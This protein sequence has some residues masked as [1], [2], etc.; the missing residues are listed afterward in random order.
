[1]TRAPLYGEHTDAVLATLA[2][3]TAD[4][5]KRLRDEGVLP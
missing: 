3:Y 1:V 2:D 5:V 4:D